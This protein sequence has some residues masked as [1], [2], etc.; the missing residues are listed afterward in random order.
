M[1]ELKIAVPGQV[2]Q[3]ELS[4]TQVPIASGAG[5]IAVA[6]NI[7]TITFA[8]AHGLTFN[9]AA[10]TMANYFIQFAGITA[11]TG[12]G[13]LNGPIFRILSIPSATT[14]TIYTTVTAGGFAAGTATPVFIPVFSPIVGSTFAGNLQQPVG[15]F[16]PPNLA[17]S[18]DV[19]FLLGP[20]CTI[21]YNPDN[22]SIVQDQTSGNTL[23]AAPT[24]RIM[25][26]VSTGGQ[27]WMDGTGAMA[28]F[29]SGGAGTTRVSVIE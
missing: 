20:N 26:A 22:T 15:T 4:T 17:A 12:I 27:V 16:F 2:F 21:Q 18:A 3:T 14:I 6:N 25:N 13:T 10:G 29:A 7:A 23:A 11:Q 24:F 19:N 9:P 28:I 5:N 8:G 1:S